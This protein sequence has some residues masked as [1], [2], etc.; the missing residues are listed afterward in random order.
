LTLGFAAGSGAGGESGD[1]ASPHFNDQAER[2]TTGA[3]REVYFYP[4]QRV[5]HTERSYHPGS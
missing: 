2:Y 4:E 1:R 3:L 5:G